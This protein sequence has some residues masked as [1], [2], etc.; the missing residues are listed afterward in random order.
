[1]NN[2]GTIKTCNSNEVIPYNFLGMRKA[3]FLAHEVVKCKNNAWR[4]GV[5]A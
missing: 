5:M 2:V 1:M 4:F 3:N